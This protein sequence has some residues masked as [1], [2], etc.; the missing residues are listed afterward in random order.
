MKITHDQVNEW[1]NNKGIGSGSN[2]T[3]GFVNGLIREFTNEQLK[4]SGD[5]HDKR[6]VLIDYQCWYNENAFGLTEP[7]NLVDRYL[8]Q[9]KP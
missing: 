8:N 4:N 3:M 1:L 9:L 2:L 5:S 6:N 7:K